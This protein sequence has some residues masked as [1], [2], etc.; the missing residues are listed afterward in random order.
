MH[1]M[2]P[3]SGAMGMIDAK[4]AT[5]PNSKERKMSS[6]VGNETKAAVGAA[7]GGGPSGKLGEAVQELARQHP[8]RH[9]DHGPH[10][11]S[12][13]HIRHKPAVRPNGRGD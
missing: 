9:D 11:A 2:K 8:I 1:E 6:S 12:S 7:Q 5:R 10:H 13:T 4:A 3:I